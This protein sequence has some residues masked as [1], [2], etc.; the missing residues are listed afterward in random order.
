MPSLH[1]FHVI[2][3][4]SRLFHSSFTQSQSDLVSLSDMQP[5][6]R[7]SRRPPTMGEKARERCLA[8]LGLV[9]L[10]C[11]SPIFLGYLAFDAARNSS[12]YTDYKRKRAAKPPK[13]ARRK[14]A[15]SI[16]RSSD[17]NLLKPKLTAEQTQSGFFSL[18]IE[19]RIAIYEE[20]V[21]RDE[22][23]VVLLNDRLFSFPCFGLQAHTCAHK[24]PDRSHNRHDW[25]TFCQP[26]LHLTRPLSQSGLGIIGTLQ[27]CRRM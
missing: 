7:R 23:Y 20:L 4:P 19:L 12:T 27:S 11:A 24:C 17:G 8:I 6:R 2:P 13:P 21:G 26:Q 25:T 16:C 5:A 1:S 9:G 18:P 3:K 14:R 22:V 15:L 10:V